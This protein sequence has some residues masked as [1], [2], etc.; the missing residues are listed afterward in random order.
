M[1]DKNVIEILARLAVENRDLKKSLKDAERGF[2]GMERQGKQA[3]TGIE[4]AFTGLE[5]KVDHVMS[6]INKRILSGAAM[7]T[8]RFAAIGIGAAV[9]GTAFSIK[10]AMDKEELENYFGEVM[11]GLSQE[12]TKWAEDLGKRWRLNPTRFKETMATFKQMTEGMGLT[13]EQ[14]FEMS[15]ALTK[16][17]VDMSSFRNVP[18]DDMFLKIQSGLS[19]EIEPL[20]RYGIILSQAQVEAFAFANG[21]AQMGADSELARRKVALATEEYKLN[22]QK[23]RE[24][25]RSAQEK[26]VALEKLAIKFQETTEKIHGQKEELTEAQKVQARFGLLMQLTAKDQGDYQRTME[27]TANRIK[28]MLDQLQIL[29][30]KWGAVFLGGVGRAAGVVMTFFKQMADWIDANKKR[31]TELVNDGV[32]RLIQAAKDLGK[33]WKENGPR[34]LEFLKTAF[35]YVRWIVEQAAK[36]PK[37]ALAAWTALSLGPKVGMMALAGKGLLGGGAAAAGAGGAGAGATGGFLG[38]LKKLGPVLLRLGAVLRPFLGPAGWLLAAAA[39]GWAL[40]RAL[41]DLIDK[42]FPKAAQAIDDFF[43]GITDRLNKPEAE[44]GDRT[45]EIMETSGL[46]EDEFLKQPDLYKDGKYIGPEDSGIEFQTADATKHPRRKKGPIPDFVYEHQEKIDAIARGKELR[47]R[48]TEAMRAQGMNP[49][50]IA[51][52]WMRRDLAQVGKRSAVGI[53]GGPDQAKAA[54][55]IIQSVVASIP[56]LQPGGVARQVAQAAAPAP[57]GGGASQDIEDAA[58]HIE[59]ASARLAAIATELPGLMR[60]IVAQEAPTAVR[61]AEM[62]NV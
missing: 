13:E 35:H 6:G 60:R 14:A 34:I 30:E 2:D 11:G 19:G 4:R 61:N 62:Q 46:S 3:V 9:G 8:K 47:K 7:W 53:A 58:G 22:S 42:K 12:A 48:Q 26:A 44:L 32:E 5:R 50:Q 52:E 39:G 18:L 1:A 57:A 23:V 33:W 17:N 55:E 16:L 24:S 59:A 38:L 49:Q 31:L 15:K 37:T 29:Q 45:K 51:E 43:Q 27:S 20:K 40:G 10:R 36:Y 25:K 54:R 41:D 28:Q 21:I 56:R